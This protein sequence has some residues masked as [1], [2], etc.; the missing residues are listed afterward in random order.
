MQIICL[1]RRGIRLLVP[2]S[3]F[4]ATPTLTVD[5]IAEPFQAV[6]QICSN[7][8]MEHNLKQ[9]RAVI[10]KAVKAGATVR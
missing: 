4:V 6:G 1:K 7:S 3:L 8:S 2:I 10:D 5:N 9:C